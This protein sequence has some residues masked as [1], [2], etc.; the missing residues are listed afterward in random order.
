[1]VFKAY[2]VYTF[3]KNLLLNPNENVVIWRLEQEE[4]GGQEASFYPAVAQIH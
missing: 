4:G 1:M 2:S 3:S